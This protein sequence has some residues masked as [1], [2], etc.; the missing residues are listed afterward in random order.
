MDQKPEY[1]L[2]WPYMQS[3]LKTIQHE[4]VIT[5]AVSLV[6]QY[7]NAV[8][9]IIRLRYGNETA[10]EIKECMGNTRSAYIKKSI[11]L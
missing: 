6:H 11:Q 3:K 4:N 9:Y 5:H 7:I 2:E 8:S 1:H 10:L